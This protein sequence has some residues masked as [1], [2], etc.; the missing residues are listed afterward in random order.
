MPHSAVLNEFLGGFV[1]H[2]IRLGLVSLLA[3][4]DI[5]HIDA[6]YPVIISRMSNQ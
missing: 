6:M 5:L 3:S 4:K 1:N 2:S